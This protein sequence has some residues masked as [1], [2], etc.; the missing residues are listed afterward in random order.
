MTAIPRIGITTSYVD[1]EQRIDRRY[2]AAVERAGGH[3]VIIPAT[4]LT[5]TLR[6]V[7]EE[8][9]GLLI[10]G[11]PA[12]TT[13]LIG[14]LPED[15]P[16]VDPFRVEN[17]SRVLT[18]MLSSHKPI[19]GICYGMQLLNARAG[20]TIYADVQAQLSGTLSHSERRGGDT[21]PVAVAPGSTIER[22]VQPGSHVN[23]RHIQAIA[24]VGIGYRPTARA[25]DGV[26]EAIESDDGRVL[27][28]QWHPEQM[29]GAGEAIFEFLVA[30]AAKP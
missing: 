16:D 1:G 9:D 25:P 12:I 29:G 22:L 7:C 14:T 13:G 11:G 23:T 2:I 20:G 24:T 4:E 10:P 21:H 27:G 6:R 5:A 8:L 30:S 3:P 15:L 18:E 28:V 19:L 26:I 17:D